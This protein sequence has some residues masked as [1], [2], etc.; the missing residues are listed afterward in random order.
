M[1]SLRMPRG[2]TDGTLKGF[3]WHELKM[4]A[5]LLMLLLANVGCALQPSVPPV[6]CPQPPAPPAWMM[7]HQ[8]SSLPLLDRIISPSEAS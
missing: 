4:I 7:E 8:P 2:S 5:L 1:N 3:P 6:E